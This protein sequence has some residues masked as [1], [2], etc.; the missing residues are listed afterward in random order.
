MTTQLLF[1]QNFILD[2]TFSKFS[3]VLLRVTDTIRHNFLADAAVEKHRL[4]C[5]GLGHSLVSISPTISMHGSCSI[6]T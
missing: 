5:P 1:L 2:L 4:S 3:W 6:G